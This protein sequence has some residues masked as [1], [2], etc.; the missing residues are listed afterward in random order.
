MN[1]EL[2]TV[3]ASRNRLA[4]ALSTC[5]S[6]L[7]QSKAAGVAEE[8]LRAV[9]GEAGVYDPITGLVVLYD[10]DGEEQLFSRE[11]DRL[12]EEGDGAA[13]GQVLAR[14]VDHDP[15]AKVGQ[16]SDF[17]FEVTLT[18][19]RSGVRELTVWVAGPEVEFHEVVTRDKRVR[20]AAG[21]LLKA[22]DAADGYVLV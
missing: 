18:D 6:E 4:D 9:L 11:L 8:A 5:R 21:E 12:L 17:D 3:V 20:A 19:R 14:Y 7:G 2:T 1:K 15:H 16:V 13:A 10:A 22:M